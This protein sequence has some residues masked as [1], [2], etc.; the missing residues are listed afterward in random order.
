MKER[1]RVDIRLDSRRDKDIMDFLNKQRSLN[2]TQGINVVIRYFIK[3]YGN[4]N[5]LLLTMFAE[6]ITKI[7]KLYSE[8]SEKIISKSHNKKGNIKKENTHAKEIWVENNTE[9]Y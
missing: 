5:P 7:N 6:D 8:K 2:I 3:D 9:E 1:T 4:K